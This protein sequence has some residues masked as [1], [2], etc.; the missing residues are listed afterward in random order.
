[1][2][3]EEKAR[4]QWL[5]KSVSVYLSDTVGKFWHSEIIFVLLLASGAHRKTS[6]SAVICH[7]FK[8]QC[9][10]LLPFLFQEMKQDTCKSFSQQDCFPKAFACSWPL[11]LQQQTPIYF[12]LLVFLTAVITILG[13]AYVLL[14]FLGNS[15][16]LLY[17]LINPARKIEA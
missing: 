9:Y 13:F 5:S 6:T 11:T 4:C 10:D 2:L 7:Y 8:R 12:F 1:M 17:D 16:L 3:C 14:G 15:L